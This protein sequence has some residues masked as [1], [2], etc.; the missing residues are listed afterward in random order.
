MCFLNSLYR[1]VELYSLFSIHTLHHRHYQT[2]CYTHWNEYFG[3]HIC[4]PSSSKTLSHKN[5]NISMIFSQYMIHSIHVN[6]Q[7]AR[8]HIFWHPQPQLLKY[9][10]PSQFRLNQYLCSQ[11]PSAIIWDTFYMFYP[12]QNLQTFV[13]EWPIPQSYGQ[14]K[15]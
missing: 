9:T 8:F 6:L 11:S 5:K 13:E 10:A 12:W 2:H 7:E 14:S 4:I 1:T 15:F 3:H